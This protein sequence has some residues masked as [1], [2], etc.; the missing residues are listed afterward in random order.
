M[1][2][3]KATSLGYLS[4]IRTVVELELRQRVRSKSWFIML[5]VW[6]LVIL[7]VTALAA[8]SASPMLLGTA[9]AEQI[10]QMMFELVISFVLLFGLLVAPALSANTITGD[11]AGGTLAI[12]QNT[13]LTPGQL[14]WGKWLASWIAALA[15]LV[16]T[17][18]MLAWAMSYGDVYLPS[19][20]LFVLMCAVELGVACAIGV[21]ISARSTRPLFA[22]VGTYLVVA[23]LGLGTLIGFGLSLSMTQETIT[24]YEVVNPKDPYASIEMDENGVPLDEDGEPV[25]N[26]E[27]FWREFDAEHA[28]FVYRTEDEICTDKPIQRT[29]LHTERTAWML[30]ANPF[31]VVADAVATQPVEAGQDYSPEGPLGAV[32]VG[33]RMAQYGVDGPDCVNGVRQPEPT[34]N[35]GEMP[36][37]WPVGLGV[38]LVLVGLLMADGRRRLVTPARKLA[39][40]TRVA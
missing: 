13:L 5:V 4:G 14:L 30:A 18:P 6:F 12:L 9:E 29:I 33:V 24:D 34:M 11:R 15:F 2:D 20:P 7:A 1:T 3:E 39:T 17:L 16:V 27:Q 26:E 25:E 38:Q 36:P 22:V 28:D 23:L 32:Q 8:Y 21:G 10:G 37:L 31:V 35:P 19:V 40:G